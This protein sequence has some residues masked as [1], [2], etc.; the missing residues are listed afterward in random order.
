MISFNRKIL[1]YI[2]LISP[3]MVIVDRYVIVARRT[4]CACGYSIHLFIE[5]LFES[6]GFLNKRAVQLLASLRIFDSA[7]SKLRPVS[8][9]FEAIRV[10]FT[11]S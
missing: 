4:E 10:A 6:Q 11:Y 2:P 8:T 5:F 3:L 7:G 9:Q 1:E